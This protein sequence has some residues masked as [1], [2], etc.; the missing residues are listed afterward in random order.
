MDFNALTTKDYVRKLIK[1]AV[2]ATIQENQSI[3]LIHHKNE[4]SCIEE[5]PYDKS[6]TKQI[7]CTECQNVDSYN[8]KISHTIQCMVMDISNYTIPVLHHVESLDR[9]FSEIM[10]K[11]LSLSDFLNVFLNEQPRF[12][13]LLRDREFCE[14]MALWLWRCDRKNNNRYAPKNFS[15]VNIDIGSKLTPCSYVKRWYPTE[16]GKCV[17]QKSQCIDYFLKHPGYIGMR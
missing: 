4:C 9:S 12:L 6:I 15:D 3:W 16:N 5:N 17:E 2:A 10:T 13:W 1:A 11:K 14:D 7:Q 8:K